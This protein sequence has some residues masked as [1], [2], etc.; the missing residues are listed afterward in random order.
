M[1][2][3]TQVLRDGER[4]DCGADEQQSG[5]QR[6]GQAGGDLAGVVG[7]EHVKISLLVNPGMGLDLILQGACQLDFILTNQQ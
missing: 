1:I 4:A 7:D 5:E 3:D 6:A 2:S